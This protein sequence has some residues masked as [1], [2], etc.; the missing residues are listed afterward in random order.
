MYVLLAKHLVKFAITPLQPVL[1]VLPMKQHHYGLTMAVSLLLNVILD[2]SQILS[3]DLVIFVR[4]NANFVHHIRTAVP[5]LMDTFSMPF[6]ASLPALILPSAMMPRGHVMIV[7]VV[8]LVQR[9]MSVL[10]AKS[11]NFYMWGSAI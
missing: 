11:I 1:H 7:Q 5:A 3:M 10:P 9:K 4:P 6:S 8:K 2:I